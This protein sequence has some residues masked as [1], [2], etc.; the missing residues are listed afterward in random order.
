MKLTPFV[1][2]TILLLTP[3]LSLTAQ[4][5][6]PKEHELTAKLNLTSNYLWRGVT[7]TQDQAAVQGVIKYQAS[8][9]II[10]ATGVSNIDFGEPQGTGYE[11]DW[12]IGY[13]YQAESV[14]WQAG[15]RYSSYPTID[16]HN[17]GDLEARVKWDILTGGV[18]YTT[19]TDESPTIEE[20]SGDLYVYLNAVWPVE[21]LIVGGRLGH[22]SRTRAGVPSYNHLQLYLR[23]EG[24]KF[25]V[26]KTDLD[27]TDG[28]VRVW[29]S[30]AKHFE[31]L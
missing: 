23:T 17:F 3:V 22:Y 15:Y 30:W 27:G 8:N 14:S 1:T 10:L 19:N 13:R 9:G 20:N 12:Y 24:F 18:A 26:N 21:G 5:D 6:E 11:Q 31:L 7:Q 2:I 16:G 4:A 29:V 28:D 25:A